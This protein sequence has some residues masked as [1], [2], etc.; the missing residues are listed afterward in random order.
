MHNEC[1]LVELIN[2]TTRRVEIVVDAVRRC[3][4]TGAL[5]FITEATFV[6]CCFS[7]LFAFLA[8]ALMHIFCLKTIRR[9]E[10][11]GIVPPKM[12][13]ESLIVLDL[14]SL[15]NITGAAFRTVS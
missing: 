9:S 14:F 3:L 15:G 12:G 1:A 11:T 8:I 7:S 4:D 2:R 10:T 6:L 5:A 13:K